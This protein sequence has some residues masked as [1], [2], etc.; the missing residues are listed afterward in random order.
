MEILKFAFAIAFICKLTKPNSSYALAVCI[1]YRHR[2]GLLKMLKL[3]FTL[4]L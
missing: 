1:C 2:L 4:C 3:S